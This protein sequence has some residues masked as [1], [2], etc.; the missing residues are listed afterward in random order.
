MSVLEKTKAAK[1]KV[2]TKKAQEAA[3]LTRKLPATTMFISKN[4]E[5]Q[6]ISITVMGEEVRSRWCKDM[7]YLTWN[8]PSHLVERFEMHEFIVQ[9]RIIRA[10]GD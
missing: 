5:I 9:G 10:E 2:V 8:V 1:A 7:E 6:D 4:E 3:S